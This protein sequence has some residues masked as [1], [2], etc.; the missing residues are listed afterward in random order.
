MQGESKMQARGSGK[1]EA[2]LAVKG[3]RE[4]PEWKVWPGRPAL[5]RRRWSLRRLTPPLPRLFLCR[6]GSSGHLERIGHM[7][8]MRRLGT[9]AS[10]GE[11]GGGGRDGRNQQRPGTTRWAQGRERPPAHILRVWASPAGRSPPDRRPWELSIHRH[12]SETLRY[13]PPR[14]PPDTPQTWRPG[15]GG[16]PP[17]RGLG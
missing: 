16:A 11:G 17:P 2:D 4:E 1:G 7:R 13:R 8:A 3:V 12:L 5:R 6:W 10:L 15:V 9:R 14:R